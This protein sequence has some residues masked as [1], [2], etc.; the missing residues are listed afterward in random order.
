MPAKPPAVSKGSALAELLDF[1]RD[2]RVWVMVNYALLFFLVMTV[3]ATGVVALLIATFARDKSP[4][5]LQGHYDFQIRTFW[6]G[7]LPSMA[8]YILG[9]YLLK[10]Q[11]AGPVTLFLVIVPVLAWTASRV[12]M[13][14]NHVLHRRPY[15]NPRA[16]LV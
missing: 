4:E 11:H 9:Q 5:W 6:I 10:V 3:G 1:L 13:G 14:F 12:A 16:W 2:P 15:P 7:V 8:A